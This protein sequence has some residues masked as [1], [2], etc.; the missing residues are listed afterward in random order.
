[1]CESRAAVIVPAAVHA[2]A[3]L[4]VDVEEV[5]AEA[6]APAP[7]VEVADDDAPVHPLKASS[8]LAAATVAA[9]R[10]SVFFN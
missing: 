10:C 9:N 2:G 1:V 8:K 4:S 3:G 5:E 7:S 6:F